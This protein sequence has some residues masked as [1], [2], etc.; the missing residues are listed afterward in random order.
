MTTLA[1]ITGL[2]LRSSF[3]HKS[4]VHRGVST[5]TETDAFG[6]IEVDS[7][8]LWGAQTRRLIQNFPIR[9]IESK[10]AL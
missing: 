10:M 4:L 2:F 9:G 8:A 5:R 3:S 6:D 1:Y 7:D